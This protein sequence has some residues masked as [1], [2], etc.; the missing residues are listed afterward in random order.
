MKLIP[1]LIL[2]IFLSGCG[3][4]QK[5]KQEVVINT[6]SVV[7][8]DTETL[9]PCPLLKEDVLV[10]NFDDALVQYGDLATLY[11]I[12]AN[13]QKISIKLLKQF[14]NIK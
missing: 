6:P 13:K 3:I 1:I 9:V 8:I 10:S 4:F 14:G 7:H 2:S 5:P 12:C 11:G